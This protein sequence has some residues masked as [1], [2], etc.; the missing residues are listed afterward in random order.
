MIAASDIGVYEGPAI[1]IVPAVIAAGMVGLA[2]AGYY[3]GKAIDK[4][5]VEI[6]ILPDGARPTP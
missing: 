1:I 3:T 5:V 6:K 4:R 2:F